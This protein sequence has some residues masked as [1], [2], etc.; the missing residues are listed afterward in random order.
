[1][2]R[3]CRGIIVIVV[4]GFSLPCLAQD[5]GVELTVGK[6][7]V[8]GHLTYRRPSA[9]ADLVTGLGGYY[10]KDS[11]ERIGWVDAWVGAGSH[12]MIPFMS[13]DVGF[14][15][16]SGRVKDT[17]IKEKIGGL[18][19]FV[20]GKY[21]LFEM[22]S[23]F[24]AS[25]ILDLL[26]IPEILS[27]QEMTDLLQVRAGVGIHIVENAS[28]LVGYQYSRLGLDTGTSQ[29]DINDRAIYFGLGLYF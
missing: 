1:M 7:L 18:G 8:D 28:I 14:K 6:T 26:Y 2:G 16:I 5:V 9:M 12:G 23:Y 11:Q 13:F 29:S 25:L 10:Q 22:T 4:W 17:G 3:W 27:F 24:P 20:S 19:F 15:G 21:S